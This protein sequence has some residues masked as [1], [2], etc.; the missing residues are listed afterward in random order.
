MK[1]WKEL[2]A[3]CFYLGNSRWLPGTLGSAVGLIFLL[4][5]STVP[6][7]I[8]L[9]LTIFFVGKICADEMISK[10]GQK[11]PQNVV[12]DE[13]CGILVTFFLNAV[14]WKT[15]V[16]GFVLFRFFDIVKP[17][18]VRRME[19]LPGGWGVMADDLVAGLYA[20]AFLKYIS[21][22]YLT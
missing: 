10:T 1:K 8:V 5:R 17:F 16:I 2:V 13:V 4:D 21:L 9:I 15:I 20:N 3:T 19:D 14:T 11:D 18:P 22:F 7:Q 6:L 12:I